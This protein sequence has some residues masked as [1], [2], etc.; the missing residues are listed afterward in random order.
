MEAFA[1]NLRAR[2]EEKGYS[3]ARMAASL[4]ITEERYHQLEDGRLTPDIIHLKRLSELL[5]TTVPDLIT[6][7]HVHELV[8]DL[9]GQFS[10][11]SLSDL[12]KDT[13]IK[14]L[15]GQLRALLAEKHGS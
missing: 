6:D 13:Y 2:R 11:E 8:Q 9:P 12:D 3:V 7:R 4:E 5:G 1:K 14:I 15:E 10:A